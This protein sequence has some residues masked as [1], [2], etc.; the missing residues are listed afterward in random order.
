MRS[1]PPG[2]TIRHRRTPL[3]VEGALIEPFGESSVFFVDA[4]EGEVGG[5]KYKGRIELA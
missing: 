4:G 1:S 2:P 5:L 3:R